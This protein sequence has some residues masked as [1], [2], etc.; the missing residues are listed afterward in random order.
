MVNSKTKNDISLVKEMMEKSSK[1]SSLSGLSIIYTGILALIGGVIIYFDLSFSLSEKEISYSQLINRNGNPDDLYTKVKLLVYIASV[2]LILSL[3]LLYV[4]AKSKAKKEN[5]DLLTPTFGRTL[6][7]LF[8]PLFAG[9][10]F[11]LFLIHHG[12]YG[13]VA[14]ATLIFYGLGL[15][16]ASKH[17]YDE[18]EKL[19]YLE[20]LL[21]ITASYFMGTGLIFWMIG[22]G[23]GHIFFGLYLYF[24]YDKVK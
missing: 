4:S 8:I 23:L 14:P 18:L 1:F 9:G 11:S 19:G 2:I 6:K 20:L 24:K 5:I 17:S 21:G 16:N 13:L 10:I 3:L 7:S 12:L 22:F 15:I